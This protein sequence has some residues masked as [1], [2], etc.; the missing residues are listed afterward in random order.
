MQNCKEG[1]STNS[2]LNSTLTWSPQLPCKLHMRQGPWELSEEHFSRY[3]NFSEIQTVAR[4]IKQ[5][6]LFWYGVQLK[7]CIAWERRW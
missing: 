1:K 6:M 2:S 5:P 3:L 7:V 4:P